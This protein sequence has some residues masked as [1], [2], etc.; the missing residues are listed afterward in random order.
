MGVLIERVRRWC[1]AIHNSV[2][3]CNGGTYCNH[4]SIVKLRINGTL[5][6]GEVRNLG[7]N[8]QAKTLPGEGDCL[9]I[10]RIHYITFERLFSMIGVPSQ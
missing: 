10:F 4:Y 3:G 1:V 6:P 2:A 5:R 9:F 8:T 7:G